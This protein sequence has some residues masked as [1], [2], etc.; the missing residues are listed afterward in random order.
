MDV[1]TAEPTALPLLA[2]EIATSQGTRFSRCRSTG[3][4]D[5]RIS[6][7]PKLD[8]SETTSLKPLVVAVCGTA[9]YQQRPIFLERYAN[10]DKVL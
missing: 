1:V 7:V 10:F 5:Q 2:K 4:F 8:S 3:I 6:T 9:V